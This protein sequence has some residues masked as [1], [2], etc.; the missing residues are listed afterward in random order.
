MGESVLER[1]RE[2]CTSRFAGLRA[3]TN[4]SVESMAQHMDSD[5]EGNHSLSYWFLPLFEVNKFHNLCT[6]NMEFA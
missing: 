1:A 6:Q 4:Y 5:A 2:R 3:S